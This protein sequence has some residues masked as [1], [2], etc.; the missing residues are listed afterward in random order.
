MLRGSLHLV[1]LSKGR[2]CTLRSS[3]GAIDPLCYPGRG[4]KNLKDLISHLEGLLVFSFKYLIVAFSLV[5]QI[6]RVFDI[7][8][9]FKLYFKVIY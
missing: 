3:S 6:K 4:V 9:D 7:I 5:S 2:C 8:T 1:L